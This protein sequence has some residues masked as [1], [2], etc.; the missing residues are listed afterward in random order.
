M[1]SQCC[2]A[3]SEAQ[4]R[5]QSPPLPSPPPLSAAPGG[6]SWAAQTPFLQWEAHGSTLLSL[7]EVPG[8]ALSSGTSPRSRG[9]RESSAGPPPPPHGGQGLKKRRTTKCPTITRA[10]TTSMYFM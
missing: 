10:S 9:L 1:S 5:Q 2:S 8:M 4:S 6:I 7:S 3:L